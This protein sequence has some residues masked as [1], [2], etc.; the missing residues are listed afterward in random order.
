MDILLVEDDKNIREM[1]YDFLISENYSVKTAIDGN[2]AIEIFKNYSFDI[3]LLDLMLPKSSGFEVL[4]YIRSVS[5]VPVIIATAK[6]SDTDKMLGLNL[7]ADD[8]ITKPFSI[9]ELLARIKANIRR[10]TVYSSSRNSQDMVIQYKDLIIN[11]SKYVVSKNGIDLNLTHTEFE[12]VKLLATNQG[13]AFSKEQLYNT[14]WKEP[15]Y[16]NENVLNTH[17]NRLRNK[18]SDGTE[19]NNYIK[20]LWGIGYK[21]EEE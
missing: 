5:V 11:I 16:G 19:K 18:L 6:D 20:T 17:I 12:I 4:K 21:M 1:V 9:V 3:I 15:Y 7:G 10:A 2:T 8:Y 14:I 13:R